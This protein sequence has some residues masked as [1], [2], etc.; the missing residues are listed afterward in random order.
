MSAKTLLIECR[1]YFKDNWT[2][3]DLQYPEQNPEFDN[4]GLNTYVRFEFVNDGSEL[5]GYNSNDLTFGYCK[6][7]CFHKNEILSVDLADDVKLFFDNKILDNDVQVKDGQIYP[8]VKLS[9]D[10]YLT[11]VQFQVIKNS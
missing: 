6:V 5:V 11:L 4:T 8:T 9:N 10:F 1:N 7:H 3:T 2:D